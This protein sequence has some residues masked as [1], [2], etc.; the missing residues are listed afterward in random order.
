MSG[1]TLSTSSPLDRALRIIPERSR[2]ILDRTHDDVG[3]S[4]M[5]ITKTQSIA[6]IRFNTPKDIQI[7]S[8]YYVT[9]PNGEVR[10][11]KFPRSSTTSDGLLIPG[12]SLKISLPLTQD[13]V[14]RIELVRADGLAYVNTTIT[15]GKVWSLIQ[16]LSEAETTTLRKNIDTIMT[17]TT[18]KINTLRL[19]LM[20]NAVSLDKELTRLAQAKA[21]DMA[22]RGY[23]G[24]Q[25]PDGNYID[26]FARK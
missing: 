15:R 6:N 3:A 4:L 13:G 11:E 18:K 5:K 16:P 7:R 21:D 17:S 25:D 20:R 9:L 10:E 2:V 24:H 1:Y 12:K 19:S 14:Y 26:G 8:E 22:M 23:A